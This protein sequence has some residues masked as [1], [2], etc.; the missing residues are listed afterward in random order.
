M[1]VY[2]RVRWEG[3]GILCD[4]FVPSTWSILEHIQ[5]GWKDRDGQAVRRGS[6]CNDRCVFH[7]GVGA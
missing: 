2:V 6:K 7:L 1:C 5:R 4:L 3:G